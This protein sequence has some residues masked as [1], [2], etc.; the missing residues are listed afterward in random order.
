M[1]A[2]GI[3][4]GKWSSYEI[5]EASTDYPISLYDKD[6]SAVFTMYTSDGIRSEYQAFKLF[7]G[8]EKR[9]MLLEW[10]MD[11]GD[12]DQDKF[13]YSVDTYNGRTPTSADV[14]VDGAPLQADT[15]AYNTLAPLNTFTL[16]VSDDTA[17]SEIRL[18]MRRMVVH[19][20]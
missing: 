14:L 15:D 4:T 12:P 10:I 13:I 6:D 7:A 20:E 8:A 11:C 2:Y 1:F 3:A 18:L 17:L 19:N 9:E 5:S 16:R